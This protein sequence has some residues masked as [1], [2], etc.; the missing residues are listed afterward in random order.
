MEIRDW[1]ERNHCKRL[2]KGTFE[3]TY[4]KMLYCSANEEFKFK[5]VPFI[6]RRFDTDY[7]IL[8]IKYLHELRLVSPLILSGKL[9]TTHVGL[10]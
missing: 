4:I 9:A 5:D 6:V 2:P 7:N 1:S 3:P 8:P 10:T